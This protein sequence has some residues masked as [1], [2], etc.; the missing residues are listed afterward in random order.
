MPEGQFKEGIAG[1]RLAPD[2]YADNFSDL[3]PPLDRHEALVEADRCYFCYDAPCM[4]ACPTSIDIPLFIREISTGN[5]LGAAETIFDQNILGGMCARV[6]PTERCARKPACARPPRAS[7]SR[8]AGCSATPPISPWPRTSSSSPARRA[9]RQDASP[10]SAPARP[11]SP[12]RTGS[13]MH[14]HDVVIFDGAPKGR[15][16][17]RIRHRRLQ[18][19]GRLRPGGGRLRPRDRRHHHRDRP[20]AR[21]RLL[22]RRPHAR[23]TTRCSSA[24]AWAASTRC[25]PRAR[26]PTGVEDAVDFIAELRQAE[27]PRRRCRSAAASSSSAAA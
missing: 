7:R 6:C 22:A 16:P 18:D 17:Q 13:R 4:N 24:W 14:G 15:R 27:R 19:A 20:G 2:Q 26:M 9:D 3:H 5:P 12:A 25:A 8:S 11:A 10:W 1:G 23:S 21:P